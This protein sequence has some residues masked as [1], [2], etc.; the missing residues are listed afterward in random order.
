MVV[1]ELLYR[2]RELDS[3]YPK[4]AMWVFHPQMRSRWR[5]A[6]AAPSYEW[7]ANDFVTA[8]QQMPKVQEFFKRL[9]D[10]GVPLAIGTDSVASGPFYLRELQ[11]SKAAGLNHWQVLQLA[12]INGARHLGLADTGQLAA[13]LVADFIVLAENP[14]TDLSALNT[15]HTVVQ[16]GIAAKVVDLKSQLSTLSQIRL[17]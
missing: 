6:I 12:T 13:G 4:Q 16:R 8:Q 2:A 5:S 14:L 15:V 7:Q 9:Y 3:L 10:A 17:Q 11:L 1:N